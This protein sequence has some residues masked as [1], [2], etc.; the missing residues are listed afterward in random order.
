MLARLRRPLQ[1]RGS[2]GRRYFRRPGY[3]R[4]SHAS[5]RALARCALRCAR[6]VAL[7][8]WPYGALAIPSLRARPAGRRRCEPLAPGALDVRQRNIPRSRGRGRRSPRLAD[9]MPV[10]LP[11]HPDQKERE[12]SDAD[13]HWQTA[14]GHRYVEEDDVKDDWA[15]NDQAEHWE[16]VEQ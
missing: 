15:E 8:L 5:R 2:R 13:G 14:L 10:M 12:D 9:Q 3:R 6:G 16:E 4:R 1:K 11:I 7:R